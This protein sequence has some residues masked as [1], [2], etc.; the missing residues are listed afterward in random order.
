VIAATRIAERRAS[1][2]APRPLVARRPRDEGSSADGSLRRSKRPSPPRPPVRR[3]V[4]M[5]ESTGTE[6]ATAPAAAAPAVSAEMRCRNRMR[7]SVPA[8]W[9]RSHQGRPQATPKHDQDPVD[10]RS[11]PYSRLISAHSSTATTRL[12]PRPTTMIRRGS[13]P[14]R[15]NPAATWVTFRP[16]QVGQSVFT[17]RPHVTNDRRISS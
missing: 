7:R 14:G 16:A 4:L 17:R 8:R 12:P 1:P 15:T 10:R 3:D 5:T 6:P 11:T 13:G 9:R 2:P